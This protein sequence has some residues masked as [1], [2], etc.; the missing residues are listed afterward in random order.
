MVL[1]DDGDV[2]APA[3]PARHGEF[4]RHKLLDLI[5]DLYAF[6]GPPLGVVRARKPGHRA[7][8]H[9]VALALEKGFLARS[10]SAERPGA[11]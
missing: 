1:G 8:H 6:G 7:T 11:W 9:A 3:L 2:E 4:A 5:G 10:E